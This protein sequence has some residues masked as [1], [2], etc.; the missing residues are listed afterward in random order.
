[1]KRKVAIDHSFGLGAPGIPLTRP[2]MGVAPRRAPLAEGRV[3]MFDA[4]IRTVSEANTRGH[5]SG[6]YSRGKGQKRAV[7]AL[8]QTRFGVTP[9]GPP[10]VVK[11]TRIAPRLLDDDNLRSAFKAIRDAIAFW[12]EVDD[13][14]PRVAWAY[15]QKK[16]EPKAYAIRVEI[17]RRTEG[18]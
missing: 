11:L 8:C 4:S 10:L 15:D 16:G 5:W 2:A 6:R 1:M 9:P 12:L 7:L 3:L 18:A 17:S 14:D 13:G